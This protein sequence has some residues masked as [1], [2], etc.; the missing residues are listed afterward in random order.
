MSVSV[1][2]GESTLIVVVVVG[3][4]NTDNANLGDMCLELMLIDNSV[5]VIVITSVE[6]LYVIGKKCQIIIT[7]VLVMDIQF[8]LKMINY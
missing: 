4:A 7:K 1:I 5:V 3:S 8:R 6:I 2:C